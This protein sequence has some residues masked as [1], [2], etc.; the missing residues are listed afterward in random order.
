MFFPKELMTIAK[1]SGA[2]FLILFSLAVSSM[3]YEGYVRDLFLETPQ[4]LSDLI[5]SGIDPIRFLDPGTMEPYS[6]PVFLTELGSL[7]VPR[8]KISGRLE[9]GLWHGP[10][11]QYSEG[12]KLV[13]QGTQNMGVAC[14]V[15]IKDNVEERYDPCP[16]GLE[17]DWSHIEVNEE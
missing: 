2:V 16:P 7:S 12:G 1:V 9:S 15:W 6:G 17:I 5:S 4:D 10:W 14:G 13:I 3:M 11:E 8:L